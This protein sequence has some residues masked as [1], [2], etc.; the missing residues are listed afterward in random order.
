MR[1]KSI[2][3]FGITSVIGGTESYL[4]S[5]M[6]NLDLSKY[7]I[8][9]MTI[10]EKKA[11]LEEEF[12]QLFNDGRN[13]FFYPPNMKKKFVKS[14]L[15]LNRFYKEHEYDIIYM[16]VTSAA[17]IV[18]CNFALMDGKTKLITHN[19][20]GSATSKLAGLNNYLFRHYTTKKSDIKLACSDE[21]FYWGF[22]CPLS[23]GLIIKNGINIDRFAYNKK[24]RDEIRRTYNIPKDA[25]VIGHIG[26]F[27]KEKN[28]K[29]LLNL[30][31]KLDK[32]YYFLCAGEGTLKNIIQQEIIKKKLAGRF[33]ILP[34]TEETEKLYS[35]MD[36][37]CMPSFYEGLPIVAV[38]AQ[39]SGLPC[40]FSDTISKQANIC[41]NNYYLS[42]E[43]TLDW[44]D[45]ISRISEKRNN[46]KNLLKENGFDIK[47]TANT[48]ERIFNELNNPEDKNE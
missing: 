19:H 7:D 39:A 27:E 47:D 32:K 46:N 44:I 4:R 1:K 26:R 25:F 2:L 12:N 15:W 18:Y 30:C 43:N 35:A 14:L 13:H 42:I 9:F 6:N 37:F 5:L 16:N 20:C 11:S 17:R 24:F 31:E 38:E 10:G 22:T 21:A 48:L 23:E 36:V 28:H 40:I 45:L 8:D 3:I 29:F 34:F 41:G 33:I